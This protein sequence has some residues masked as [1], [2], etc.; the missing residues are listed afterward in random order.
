[1]GK[2]RSIGASLIFLLNLLF[3]VLFCMALLGRFIPVTTWPFLSFLVLALPIFVVINVL[4]VGYWLFRRKRKFLWSL[5][6]L[7]FGLI[8]G[9]PIYKFS[10]TKAENQEGGLKIMTFNAFG[11][12]YY[13]NA[14]KDRTKDSLIVEMVRSEDPDIV[15]FQEFHYSKIKS[16]DFDQYPHRYVNFIFGKNRHKKVV[17]AIYSKYP[18]LE[19][20]E[21]DF[22]SSHNNALYADILYQKDTIRLYN[23]HLQ[24]FAVPPS[25]GEL[26]DEPSERLFKR[27]SKTF[28]KHQEQAEIIKAHYQQVKW[29]VIICGDFNNTQNSYPYRIIQ[30]DLIDTFDEKGAG[31]GT[32]F[33]FQGFP[34]KIDHILVDEQFTVLAHKNYQEEL[35]DHFPV[36][37]RLEL[38]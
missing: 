11:F 35:S 34:L 4:F 16:H 20:G 1:M 6:L 30:G 18:I 31:F 26:Y 36:C 7:I 12:G 27:M 22:P 32:T 13:F 21:V 9:K 33:D 3:G 5:L 2:V 23:L 17:Q 15:S 24:S 14:T 25:F 37:A 19:K 29:P 28:V 10:N 8:I 38:H